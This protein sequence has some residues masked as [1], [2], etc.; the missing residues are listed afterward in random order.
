MK[1][2]ATLHFLASVCAAL[3]TSCASNRI[4]SIHSITLDTAVT[5]PKA[6]GY[7]NQASANVDNWQA[8]AGLLPMLVLAGVHQ[9]VISK[10]KKEMEAA[11]AS[12]SIA[13]E[14][15]VPPAFGEEFSRSG[16]FTVAPSG[17]A[18]ATLKLKLLGYGVNHMG[19]AWTSSALA[20]TVFVEA[21]LVGADGRTIKALKAGG[22][23]PKTDWHTHEQYRDN[24]DLLR[25]GWEQAARVAARFVIA[26]LQK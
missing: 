5:R 18:D 7:S 24:P 3:L 26:K 20:T 11:V 6:M 2:P 21:T 12:R 9:G 22:T 19:G 25:T 23:A 1:L 14:Q 16:R 4:A 10:P 8:G 13:I 17:P 15:I